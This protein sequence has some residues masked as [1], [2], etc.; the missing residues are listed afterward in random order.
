MRIVTTIA[1]RDAL[2]PPPLL[3][4]VQPDGGWKCYDTEEEIPEAY[5]TPTEPPA[6]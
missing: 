6:P 4:E 2:K 5:K 3:C 1:E